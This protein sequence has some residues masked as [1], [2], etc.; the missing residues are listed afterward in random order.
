VIIANTPQLIFSFLYFALNSLL[1]SMSSAAEWSGYAKERKSLRV[2]NKPQLSQRSNYFLSIPY[3]YAVPL[4]VLSAILHWL[5]SE[6]LFI[7]DIEAWDANMER[8]LDKDVVTCGY[9]PAAILSAICVGAFMFICLVALAFRPLHSAMPVAGSC[10]LAIAAA[11]HPMFDPNGQGGVDSGIE[12]EDEEQE[13]D[14]SLLLVQWGAVPVDGPIGHCSFTSGD[15]EM[16][17]TGKEYQ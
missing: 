6:S 14:M 15:V 7:V 10:S 5:I 13:E 8:G 17:E 4:I 3:R 2:S 9:S 16:P 11:C 1:T 12:E